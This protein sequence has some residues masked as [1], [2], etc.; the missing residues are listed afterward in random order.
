[1]YSQYKVCSRGQTSP[2]TDF[3]DECYARLRTA[4]NFCAV[5]RRKGEVC[6]ME[7]RG[8]DDLIHHIQV[9]AEDILRRQLFIVRSLILCRCQACDQGE[10]GHFEQLL[11]LR[12]VHS[13][14]WQAPHHTNK[15]Y[16][17]VTTESTA[18]GTIWFPWLQQVKKLTFYVTTNC[19]HFVKFDNHYKKKRHKR[20]KLGNGGKSEEILFKFSVPNI[21]G[22]DSKYV[23]NPKSGTSSLPKAF[24]L[25]S[26]V[27]FVIICIATRIPVAYSWLAVNEV[28]T[29]T[30]LYWLAFDNVIPDYTKL[31]MCDWP[32]QER[33]Y[34]KL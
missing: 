8:C 23:I 19:S 3:L 12:R 7:V 25:T 5:A 34:S 29:W 6:V 1:M 26:G 18:K 20:Y 17:D 15:K 24:I 22:N 4:L 28:I 33:D 10:G 11:L 21:T 31:Y 2:S 30:G 14:R 32:S 16:F 9:T 27:N 13:V